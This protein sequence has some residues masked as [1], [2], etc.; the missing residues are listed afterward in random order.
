[1][2]Q[3]EARVSPNLIQGMIILQ[4]HNIDALFD[5]GATYSFVS[6]DCVNK[7]NLSVSPLP[8]DVRVSALAGSTIKTSQ[9]CLN[10]PLKFQDKDTII[11]LVCL[12]LEG[13]DVINGMDWLSSHGV[14][15]DCNKKTATFSRNSLLTL[16]RGE[17]VLFSTA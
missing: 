11:D 17:P 6:L 15:L 3:E 8:Y 9:A 4:G 16:P 7:L 12:P 2:T 1:M 10:L 13:I 5:Y 14:V